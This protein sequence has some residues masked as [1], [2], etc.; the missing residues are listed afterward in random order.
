V[1]DGSGWAEAMLGLSGVRVT[2]VSETDAELMIR[3]EMS[4]TRAWCEMCGA[5]AEARDRMVVDVRYL[6]CFGGPSRLVWSKRHWRCRETLCPAKTWT[7]RCE[8]LDAQ[9]VLSSSCRGRSVPPGRRARPS[10]IPGRRRVRGVLVDG[11][12]RRDRARHPARG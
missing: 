4:A 6:E 7:E 2:E 12:V 3:V 10:A 1:D 9:M 11:D 5:R 8:H